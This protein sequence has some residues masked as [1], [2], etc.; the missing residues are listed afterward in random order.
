M[1]GTAQLTKKGTVPTIR[2]SFQLQLCSEA[3]YL[4]T[5]DLKSSLS[6]KVVTRATVWINIAMDKVSSELSC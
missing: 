3:S 5:P 4:V 2:S 1:L 6:M